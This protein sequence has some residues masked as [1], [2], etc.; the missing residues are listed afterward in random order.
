M[1]ASKKN[2]SVKLQPKVNKFVTQFATAVDILIYA[3]RICIH[4][5]PSPETFILVLFS[6]QSSWIVTK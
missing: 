6:L 3:P 4:F 1:C 2:T 5:A